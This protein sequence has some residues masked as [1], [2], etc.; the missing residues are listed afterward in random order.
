MS[1]RRST[2]RP[3]VAAALGLLL[4]AGCAQTGA[5]QD[6]AANPA[7][8][9]T[10]AAEGVSSAP[11]TVADAWAKA[12]PDIGSADRTG[13]FAELTNPGTEPVVIVSAS[14]SASGTTEMHETVTQDGV[15]MMREVEDGFEI[16]PGATRVLR[17][18]G[19]HI[20]AMQLTEPLAVGDVVT[21]TLTTST[22]RTVEFDAVAKEFTGANER[23]AGDDHGGTA[24]TAAPSTP[25]AERAERA[26][27]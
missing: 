14:T 6:P 2:V 9:T 19:D 7:A 3:S 8:S 26:S 23:Y 10:S 17:P 15:P 5:P 13:V 11:V 12:A 20:M 4:L 24:A 1:A 16:A 27:E 18:G 21:V 22:D 25:A